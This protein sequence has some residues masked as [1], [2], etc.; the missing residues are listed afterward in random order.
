MVIDPEDEELL[1]EE[2]DI[3]SVEYAKN[4]NLND[5]SEEYSYTIKIPKDRIAVLIG[6]KGQVKKDL[7]DYSEADIRVDSSEGDVTISGKD[8]LK[9]FELREVVK[10]IARGFNPDI[11]KLLL[12]PDYSLE[13]VSL[14]DFGVDSRN[15]LKRVRSRVIGT[16]GKAR[17]ALEDLTGTFIRVY[18]KTVSILG[19]ISQVSIAKRA[20][21]SLVKGSMHATVYKWLEKQRRKMKSDAL[22]F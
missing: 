20:I 18:G 22:N 1:N 5:G 19:E 11:A 7:E 13:I 12:K 21:E 17:K 6:V 8:A 15:K 2:E 16:E 4:I 3:E 10:A 14:K 9:L